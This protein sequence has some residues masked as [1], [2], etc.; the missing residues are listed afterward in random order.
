M[1][2]T[3]LDFQSCQIPEAVVLGKFAGAVR[4]TPESSFGIS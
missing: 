3:L 2:I 4:Q 1:P